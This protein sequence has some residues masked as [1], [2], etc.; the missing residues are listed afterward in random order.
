M[1]GGN[2]NLSNLDNFISRRLKT[3]AHPGHPYKNLANTNFNE[4]DNR[5]A[6][7]FTS[8]IGLALRTVDNAN[9]IS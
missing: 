6:L 8:A 9:L 5:A 4:S 7:P 2:A 1:C 3:A